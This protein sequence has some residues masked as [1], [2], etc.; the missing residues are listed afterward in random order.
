[1]T[2]FKTYS[3]LI[4]LETFEERLSYLQLKGIVGDYTFGLDRYLN[5]IFY[6]SKEWEEI[7]R[8]VI[9]RDRGCD[10]GLADMPI[11]SEK[12][13]VH[14]MNPIT[15]DMLRSKSEMLLNPEFLISVSHST[16]NLIHFGY[17]PNR[18]ITVLERSPNDT[19]PWRKMNE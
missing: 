3:D 19:C 16:H 1:M 8:R 9:L 17:D 6:K 7:K 15:M 18:P 2:K 13:I 11:V 4:R 12:V 5:Q 10:L 14:H